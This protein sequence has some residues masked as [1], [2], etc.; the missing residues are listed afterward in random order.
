MNGRLK[1]FILILVLTLSANAQTA[2]FEFSPGV[3]GFPFK[4]YRN[5]HNWQDDIGAEDLIRM[6]GAR[7]ACKAGTT[8]RDCVL[9]EAASAWIAKYLKAMEIGHC[10]G[11]GVASLKLTGGSPFKSR[12]VPNQFQNGA[13]SV[14]DLRLSPALENY[15]AYYWI[16]QS[17][18]EIADRSRQTGKLGPAAIAQLVGAD[19]KS[20]RETYL[21]GIRKYKAGRIFDGHAV[22][23]FAVEV[24]PEQYRISVYDNNYPGETRYLTVNRTGR[25][26]WSYNGSPNSRAKPDYVGDRSTLTLEATATSWRD[27]RCF[28]SAF[29]RDFERETACGT[30]TAGLPRA[31]FVNARYRAMADADGEEAEFFL[32]GEGEML[33]TVPDGRR[34]GFDPNAER[35]VNE[36]PEAVANPLIGGLGEDAPRIAIPYEATEERYEIVFSGRHIDRENEI[37]FVFSAPGFTVGFEGILLDP[38][39]TLTASI[40][41]DGQEIT[42][43]ASRDGETPEVFYAF[44]PLDEDD[45]ASYYTNIDGLEL[46]AGKTLYYDFDF[47]NG[48]LFFSDDDGNEDDFDIELVRLLPDGTRQDY[49]N[50]DIDIGKADRYEMD[51]GDW[52]GSGT[53]CFKDDEDGDGFE[54]EQCDEEVNEFR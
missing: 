35:Y 19:L 47:A 3:N 4:N 11:I 30:E 50:D 25:Q 9:K 43:T 51:F 33:I 26:E 40:S 38:N 44:D 5:E 42:F 54:D 7:A 34:V 32:T 23:P 13:R 16:T 6:F 49:R 29:A 28:D 2:R 41:G 52:D 48:K 22:T 15:I 39:E 12:R 24:T 8:A 17:F 53:M 36:I 14:F 27:G 20:G 1:T 10:E 37:D 46:T 31:G 18:K 21:L 45:E